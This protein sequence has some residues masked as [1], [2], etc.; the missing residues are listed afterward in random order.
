MIVHLDGCAFKEYGPEHFC[1]CGLERSRRNA[2]QLAAHVAR[3][4]ARIERRADAQ[5]AERQVWTADERAHNLAMNLR[6][7]VRDLERALDDMTDDRDDWKSRVLDCL[8]R[9]CPAPALCRDRLE[10]AG[11]GSTAAGEWP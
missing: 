4:Q 3:G 6:Q 1:D 7:R 2:R 9:R 10:S 8:A 5:P 11:S